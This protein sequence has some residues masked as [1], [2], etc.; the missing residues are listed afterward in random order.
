[1]AIHIES[2]IVAGLLNHFNGVTL[3]SGATVAY[4]N[5]DFTAPT[6]TVG[7]KVVPVPYVRLVVRKNVPAQPFIRGKREPIRMGLFMATVCWPS[8][9]GISQAS[10][11]AGKI[12]DHYA[13]NDSHSDRR[14]ID[15][16][17]IR[18]FIGVDQEV[19]VNDD[20]QGSVYTEIPVIVPW[21]V[22]P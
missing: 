1:M 14:V 21:K 22:I 18:I 6:V 8:G 15:Y 19:Q 5:V 2:K 16:D 7:G 10:E 12:R 4:P 20:L 3:P 11:L 13:F 9:H 17:G